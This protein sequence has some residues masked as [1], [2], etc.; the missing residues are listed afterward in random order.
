MPR[1]KPDDPLVQMNVRIPRSMRVEI[2]SRSMRVGIGRDE[3]LR[4]VMEWA[5]RQ[6]ESSR[7]LAVYQRGTDGSVQRH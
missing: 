3:W 1:A 2:E 4:R 5:L 6:P 7:V